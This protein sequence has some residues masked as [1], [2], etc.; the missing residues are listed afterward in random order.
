[1]K[2]HEEVMGTRMVR[3]IT[4]KLCGARGRGCVEGAPG[5]HEETR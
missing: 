3:F 1:M 4:S 2:G 5:R